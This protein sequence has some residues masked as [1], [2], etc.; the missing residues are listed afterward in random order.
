M[1]P[2]NVIFRR[3]GNGSPIGMLEGV[4]LLLSS[5]P[6]FLGVRLG[7]GF[8]AMGLSAFYGILPSDEE[9]NELIKL[10]DA[11]PHSSTSIYDFVIS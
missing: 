2:S 8:G 6:N 10:V 1:A 9:N 4:L 5:F 3:L 7:L 11:V